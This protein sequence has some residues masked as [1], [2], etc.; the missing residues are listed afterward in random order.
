MHSFM[1]QIF[2]EFKNYFL[3]LEQRVFVSSSLMV[4][5]TIFINYYHG[6]N[7]RIS[8][9]NDGWQI[10]S[11]FAVF[12]SIFTLA[13]LFTWIFSG[14]NFFRKKKFLFLLLLAPLLFAWKM[15]HSFFFHFTD[16]ELMNAYWSSSVYWPFKLIIVA[17]VL[18]IV[19]KT[20]DKGKEMFGLNAKGFSP[21]PYWIMLGIM[22]PIIALAS[23][24]PDFL[25]FYP[26]LKNIN[27]LP[28]TDHRKYY[29]LFYEFCYGIDFITIELFFRG[30][31]VLAFVKY[32]GKD[33]I[34]PMAAFY[35]TIHF[36]KPLGECISSF[37]G[38]LLLGVVTY[39]T[40]TIYGG[41]IVHLGIA[42]MMELGGAIGN[43]LK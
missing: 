42:W 13:Y 17:A 23:T 2:T 22:V 14:G 43:Y 41:L 39:H 5:I 12:F 18:F 15:S 21:K 16:D 8:V 32:A 1:K 6:L 35:C 30:F 27:Y 10:V 33:A 25:A 38:G 9:L 19:W 20:I 31:L 29:Q 11:W 26:K 28:E 3:Q 24:Q 36:G 4:A 40:R 37:F 34:L 7:S